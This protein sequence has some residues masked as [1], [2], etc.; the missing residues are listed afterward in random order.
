MQVDSAFTECP[1]YAVI[2]IL[3]LRPCKVW[4]LLSLVPNKSFFWFC[5]PCLLRQFSKS[6]TERIFTSVTTWL[7]SLTYNSQNHSLYSKSDIVLWPISP[8]EMEP[9]KSSSL[10]IF[11][12]TFQPWWPLWSHQEHSLSGLCSWYLLWLETIS[13]LSMVPVPHFMKAMLKSHTLEL[14]YLI[15]FKYIV[16]F[17]LILCQDLLSLRKITTNMYGTG[18]CVCWCPQHDLIFIL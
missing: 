18:S 16:N 14:C 12:Y 3:M 10:P 1:S 15:I 4:V 2:L 6:F 17:F 11:L 13:E 8:T 7:H 5:S 9:S